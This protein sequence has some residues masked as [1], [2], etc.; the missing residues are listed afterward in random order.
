MLVSDDTTRLT[1]AVT[2]SANNMLAHLAK[3]EIVP[4]DEPEVTPSEDG[5][6]AR[7]AF[8]SGAV[9]TTLDTWTRVVRFSH[10]DKD[11]RF[12][13]PWGGIAPVDASAIQ[14]FFDDA[15]KAAAEAAQKA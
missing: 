13:L 1:E 5:E 10:M 6:A 7:I 3:L 9:N 8:R 12:T 4:A 11:R 15:E 2:R 14:T